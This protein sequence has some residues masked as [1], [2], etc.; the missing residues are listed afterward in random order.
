MPMD[1]RSLVAFPWVMAMDGRTSPG[2][3][4]SRDLGDGAGAAG[5]ARPRPGVPSLAVL[6]LATGTTGL[7]A[8]V[9]VDWS[10]TIM[11]GLAGLD[12]RAFVTAFQELSAAIA[13]PLFIGVEFTGALIFTAAAVALHLRAD[14]RAVLP[15]VGVAL[16]ASLVT[17]ATTF[18]VH[19][20]LNE[21]LR[22]VERPAGD[23]AFAAARAE[24]DEER[25]TRWNTV[26]AVASTVAFL[27]LTAALLARGRVVG[28]RPGRRGA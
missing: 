2:S 6:V 12:D 24:F 13:N 27:C 8:G 28:R 19:E 20:P 11:P 15:W 10:N 25:W 18:G 22:A 4:R 14:R 1:R 9:F 26:R 7:T 21:V 5:D 17:A 3:A 16:L 23:A